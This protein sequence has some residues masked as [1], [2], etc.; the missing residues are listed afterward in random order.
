MKQSPYACLLQQCISLFIFSSKYYN[1]YMLETTFQCQKGQPNATLLS[2]VT[3]NNNIKCCLSTI[4]SLKKL[5]T[6]AHDVLMYNFD[7]WNLILFIYYVMYRLLHQD[8]LMSQLW[9]VVLARMKTR[10]KLYLFGTPRNKGRVIRSRRK[11]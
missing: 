8:C 7:N 5:V 11:K 9:C 2:R 10:L 3:P 4:S 6:F 1:I